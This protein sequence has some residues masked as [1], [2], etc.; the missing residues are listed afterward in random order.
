MLD[1]ALALIN[2]IAVAPKNPLIA[3]T[4]ERA[5]AEVRTSL[6]FRGRRC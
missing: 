1:I 6:A 4:D 2:R 3:A 5:A